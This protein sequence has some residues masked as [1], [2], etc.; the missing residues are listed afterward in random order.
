MHP[1][2]V[3]GPTSED[4]LLAL[5]RRHHR[6]KH[7]G[8]WT[9]K[10]ADNDTAIWTSP[11][12]RTYSSIPEPWNDGPTPQAEAPAT[13]IPR[14]ANRAP[15][16]SAPAVPGTTVSRTDAPGTDASTTEASGTGT[17][18]TAV[19][20]T[21]GHDMRRKSSSHDPGTNRTGR[22]SVPDIGPPSF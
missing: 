13:D 21:G 12:G 7:D 10:R 18:A 4:N 1:H 20:G 19:T 17:S 16:A 22:E 5:C 6:A 2:A 11:T 15:D 3:G 9:V 8:G 14:V